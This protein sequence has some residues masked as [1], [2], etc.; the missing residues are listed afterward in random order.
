MRTEIGSSHKLLKLLGRLS[1]QFLLWKSM[2]MKF[3]DTQVDNQS[4]NS[5]TSEKWVLQDRHPFE[6]KLN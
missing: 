5:H 3:Y 4:I 2:N 1:V 6:K